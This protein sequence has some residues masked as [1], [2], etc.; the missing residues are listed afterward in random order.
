MTEWWL[1][2]Y[3]FS[4][5]TAPPTSLFSSIIFSL[6]SLIYY[7][8]RDVEAPSP[9]FTQSA[10]HSKRATNG[11]HFSL[12]SQSSFSSKHINHFRNRLNPVSRETVGD[13]HTSKRLFRHNRRLKTKL[14]RLIN[15]L[16]KL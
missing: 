9:T 3:I 6:F 5:G 2:E 8:M 15:T 12:P 1:C 13:F 4:Y 11:R 7:L 16:F 14:S 10:T